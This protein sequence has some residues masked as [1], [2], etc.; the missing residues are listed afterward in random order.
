[1]RSN[2]YIVCTILLG[3]IFLISSISKAVDVKSFALLISYFNITRNPTLV[4][5]AAVSIVIFEFALGMT[6]ILSSRLRPLFLKM[7]LAML[8][9]FTGIIVYGWVFKRLEDCGCL[10]S[11]IKISPLASILKNIV[12]VAMNIYAICGLTQNQEAPASDFNVNPRSKSFQTAF[13]A[14]CP[15]LLIGSFAWSFWGNAQAQSSSETTDQPAPETTVQTAPA[16]ADR[17]FAQFKVTDANN[18]HDLGQDTYLVAFLSDSCS[19]CQET[20]AKLNSVPKGIGQLP[21][22]GLILGEENTLRQFREQF[23]PQ[24]PMAIVKPLT[25]F[26]FIGNAPPRFYLIQNG[27]SLRYW[28]DDLPKTEE[29]EALLPENMKLSTTRPVDSPPP[30]RIANWIKGDAIDLTSGRG[31]NV[32]LIEFWATW[33]PPCLTSIPHLTEIQA[34]YKDQGLVVIGI[35]EE[36][37]DTVRPFV[38]QMGKRMDY[39]V[40]VDNNGETGIAYM[41]ANGVNTIPH[42]FLIDRTGSVVWHGNPLDDLDLHLRRVFP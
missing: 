25:F 3:A 19:H 1:M 35:S 12:M 26:E 4:T 39:R 8:I 6:L 32:Y 34:R 17:P 24:F 20:V 18:T 2:R 11:F 9:F 40:A 13:A 36:N 15:L 37:S 21:V 10:G 28:D 31:K 42:A 41:T 38:A 5:I 22:V 7:S 29:I 27:K 33:C 30:L 23:K 16:A 14:I